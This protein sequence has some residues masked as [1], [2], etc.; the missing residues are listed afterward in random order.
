MMRAFVQSPSFVAPGCDGFGALGSLLRNQSEYIPAELPVWQS[1]LLPPNE[2]RRATASVRLAFRVAEQC[3]QSATELALVFCSSDGDLPVAQRICSALSEAAPQVSPTDFHNSV[4]NAPAGYW[5][6]ASHA[7]GP[8]TAIAAYDHSFAAGLLE[9][10]TLV[11]VEAQATLLVCYEVPSTPP[12]L[13]KRH[14]ALP[15]AAGMVLTPSATPHTLA[16]L[17]LTVG[18][19]ATSQ[20]RHPLLREWQFANP[21][22]RALPLLECLVLRQSRTVVLQG[23]LDGSLLIDIRYV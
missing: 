11:Q 19:A 20:S 13:V 5:S 12:L 7:V 10:M 22:G 17:S 6:I 1:S 16:E 15:M 2:R 9:A 4:H 18:D 14:I 8:A 3:A 21:A 23:C